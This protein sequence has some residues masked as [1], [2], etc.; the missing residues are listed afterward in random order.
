M[1]LTLNVKVMVPNKVIPFATNTRD[2][3][4]MYSRK[5]KIQ[6]MFVDPTITP[7]IFGLTGND[8]GTLCLS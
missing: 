7:W 2:I 5:P 4:L 3:Y 6:N 1:D 8:V